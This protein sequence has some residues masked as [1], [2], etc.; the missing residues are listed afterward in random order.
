[1]PLCAFV[2]RS[3]R[4]VPACTS[5]ATID[6]VDQIQC[7]TTYERKCKKNCRKWPWHT[8]ISCTVH[9]LPCSLITA[10]NVWKNYYE[11]RIKATW[12]WHKSP[13]YGNAQARITSQGSLRM[14][15][16]YCHY[17]TS[18]W[19]GIE[20]ITKCN[21]DLRMYSCWQHTKQ[22][23]STCTRVWR[24]VLLMHV[25]VLEYKKSPLLPVDGYLVAAL[26]FG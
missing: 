15:V 21:L 3:V 4:Y 18:F 26:V 24:F 1:M 19:S 7:E 12:S 6:N 23:T 16:L 8:F 13:I 11:S 20:T 17:V 5:K 14:Q 9:H 2:L 10:D 25:H 22:N